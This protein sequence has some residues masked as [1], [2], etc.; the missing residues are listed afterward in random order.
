[1]ESEQGHDVNEI[2]RPEPVPAPDDA[3]SDVNTVV[4]GEE[5]DLKPGEDTA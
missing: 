2:N 4:M 5:V 1:M 3:E